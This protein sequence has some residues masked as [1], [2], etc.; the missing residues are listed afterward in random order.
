MKLQKYLASSALAAV[1]LLCIPQANAGLL[2][3]LLKN[4][5]IQGL[6]NR[7]DLGTLV[8]ACRDA[9]FRQ[10]NAANCTNVETAAVLNKLPPEMRAVMNNPQTAAS[11]R[12]ICAAVAP[13]PQTNSYLC[14]QLR[15]A[16]TAVGILAK[17]VTPTAAF[18][19]SR[20]VDDSN[21]F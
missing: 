18:P 2:D 12:D 21:K 16:E 8:A 14:V 10:A 7:P 11:L 13:M 4:P 17:P 3:E 20:P 9:T 5:N 19:G 15:N 6:V 1:S